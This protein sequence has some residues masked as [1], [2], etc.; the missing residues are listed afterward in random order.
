MTASFSYEIE[1][2][3]CYPEYKGQPNV[4]ATVFYKRIITDGDK[5]A[6]LTAQINVKA[7]PDEPFVPYAELTPAQVNNWVYASIGPDGVGVLDLT[8]TRQ[9]N[10]ENGGMSSPSLP[11]NALRSA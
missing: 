10:A 5:T 9:L 1:K 11:W 7:I 4:V 2:L 3:E 8:L 6:S